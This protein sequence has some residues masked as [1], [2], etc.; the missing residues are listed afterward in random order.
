M[1]IALRAAYALALTVFAAIGATADTDGHTVVLTPDNFDQIIDGSKHALVE[2][3]APWCGHCKQ[4]APTYE[5][6]AES[7][8]HSKDKV[9]IA[10]VDAD[11]HRSLGNRFSVAGFPTLKWFAKGGD[12]DDPVDYEG[13][14]SLDDLV[15]FVTRSS[16]IKTKLV[17]EPSHVVELTDDNFHDIVM[18]ANKN[19]LVEFF[20]PW[21]GHCKQLV[22]VYEKVAR[23]FAREENV[24]IASLDATVHTKAAARFSVRGYPTIKFFSA[25][26][27]G[28]AKSDLNYEGDRSEAAFVSFLNE[29]AKTDRRVGGGLGEQAGR[30]EKLDDLVKKFIAAAAEERDAIVTE[31]TTL[32][33]KLS[34]R[35]AEY[36]IKVMKKVQA[37]AEYTAKELARL[38]KVV[39]AGTITEDKLD[40]FTIRQNILRHFVNEAD[41]AGGDEDAEDRDE[42]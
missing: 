18:D 29:R 4:L 39:G 20:A 1:R 32:A 10:K 26:P 38:I 8:Q 27:P 30:I 17:K 12:V 41:A 31:A 28:R 33:D 42:L 40:F 15:D 14:R 34:S 37:N 11:A 5:E 16:G 25:V 35:A 21:C 9:V 23:D 19:V 6:L 7:F 36:Y 3:Y 24:V 13:G 22:P 2:F